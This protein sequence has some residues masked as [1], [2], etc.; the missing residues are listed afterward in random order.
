MCSTYLDLGVH[1]PLL[2]V[3]L[4][5]V[6][7]VHLEVV[8]GKLLLDALLE[9]LTLFQGQGI[10][11][12]DDGNNV[13]DIRQLL[14]HD[15]ID[16]LQGVTGG[17]DEEQAAVDTG[18][19]DVALTLGSELLSK[20]GRVLVL[21]VLDDRVPAAVVVDQVTVARGID[22]VETETNAILLNKVGHGVDLGS[23][24]DDL[25]GYKTTLRLDKV[26]GKDGVDEGRLSETSLACELRNTRDTSAG[27]ANETR[28]TI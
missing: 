26:R 18:V 12:G 13:D 3:K 14:E 2:L 22:N 7:G 4:I 24:S 23:G 10:G 6:V 17:L 11:L 28:A 1:S 8:E 15:N 20:V 27:N 9:C 5:V 25:L 19:L 16:G 21:D